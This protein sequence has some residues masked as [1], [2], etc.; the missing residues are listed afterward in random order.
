MF[1]Q[2]LRQ[3]FFSVPVAVVKGIIGNDQGRYMNP[4]RFEVFGEMIFNVITWDAIIP[5]QGISESQ[6]LTRVTR[7]G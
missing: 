5:N 3:A 7:I 4:V 1:V 6:D 2:P